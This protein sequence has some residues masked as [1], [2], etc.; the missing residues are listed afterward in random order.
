MFSIP[1]SASPPKRAA[2]SFS[3][4]SSYALSARFNAASSVFLQSYDR[5]HSPLLPHT[6]SS[7]RS[8]SRSGSSRNTS[9]HI[10]S[11][12]T[13]SRAN[14]SASRACPTPR[15]A[16]TRADRAGSAPASLPRVL[17]NVPARHAAPPPNTGLFLQLTQLQPLQNTSDAKH[18]QYSFRH[19]D[20]RQLH[21]CFYP[22]KGETG[23][24]NGWD[25]GATR[26]SWS[27]QDR[28]SAH[29]QTTL[30]RVT[31]PDH[32]Y[33]AASFS[34]SSSTRPQRKN[35]SLAT[36]TARAAGRLRFHRL[37]P[38]SSPLS[39]LSLLPVGVNAI[40]N[41]S[42]RVR[43]AGSA[44][45]R[46]SRSPERTRLRPSCLQTPLQPHSAL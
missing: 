20:F 44:A 15:A 42:W 45:R 3:S 22:Q 12:D 40:A 46:R 26:R 32:C 18:S 36:R 29:A 13:C 6:D 17:S 28:A 1:A 43:S 2:P 33:Q 41:A 38:S 23:K 11:S 34:T 37:P 7:D 39:S 5:L 21:V 27:L 24:P 31:N 30:L 25:R 19:R 16:R 10:A 4:S 8:K 35:V 9:S 14:S